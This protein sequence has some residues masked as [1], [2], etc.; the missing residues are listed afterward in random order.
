[1]TIMQDLRR[2][3]DKA[4]RDLAVIRR[5]IAAGIRPSSRQA[6]RRMI[7]DLL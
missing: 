7:A 5:E 6:I 3:R 1:M 2:Q 4:K